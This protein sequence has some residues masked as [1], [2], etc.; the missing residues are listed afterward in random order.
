VAIAAPRI[1][2]FFACAG[3]CMR[4]WAQ[5]ITVDASQPALSFDAAYKVDLLHLASGGLQ[6]GTSA[7]GHL[8]LKLTA[9]MDKAWGWSGTTL[10]LNL[11]HDHGDTFNRDRVGSLTGVSNVEV[12][13][14][15]ERLFQAWLQREWQDGTYSLLAGLYP[16][17]S[18]FQVLDTAS[19]FV[20]P[21]HGASGDLSLTRGPSIF[22][23]SSF[24]VRGKWVSSNRRSYLQAA[25]LDGIPG[26]PNQPKGTHIVWGPNDGTMGIVEIGWHPDA[27]PVQP[28]DAKLAAGL[29]GYSALVD[30]LRDVD[31]RGTPV[32]RRSAGAYALAEGSL[33]R[34]DAG[35]SLSGFMRYGVTDGDSTA[36]RAIVNTGLVL[37]APVGGRPDDVV[38]VAYSHAMVS[39]K[40]RA[41]Q[42]DAGQA[43]TAF[44][45]V[46]E[47]SYRIKPMQGLAV[48]PIVQWIANPGASRSVREATVVGVRI[49][50][51]F[52]SSDFHH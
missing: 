49:E 21:S 47:F 7:M 28:S 29:W 8:D 1:A 35:R 30:D 44:E 15:T 22:N 38:G 40:Y 25:V 16:I 42:E 31:A 18:E 10:F 11:L 32:Q 2:T 26:D 4:A 36:I 37:R 27:A 41:V 39:D 23:N 50:V 9:D 17:D 3:L 19:L 46:W 51:S 12:A 5:T 43:T 34:G 13:V 33:W 45:S 6:R 48:Q 24:G 20:H 52:Q 14:T